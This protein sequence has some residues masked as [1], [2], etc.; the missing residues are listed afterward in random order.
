MMIEVDG[1]KIM[2]ELKC[3]GKGLNCSGCKYKNQCEDCKETNIS[4]TL[5]RLQENILAAATS[6][7]SKVHEDMTNTLLATFTTKQLMSEL[8]RRGKTVGKKR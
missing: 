5:N 1:G 6:N 7:I 2:N 3:K 4:M 8:R